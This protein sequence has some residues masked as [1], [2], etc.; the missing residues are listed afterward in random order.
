MDLVLS[1]T[2]LSLTSQLAQ[3]TGAGEFRTEEILQTNTLW[4]YTI[5]SLNRD[6]FYYQGSLIDESPPEF[7]RLPYS[8]SE[9]FVRQLATND[10]NQ[11]LFEIEFDVLEPQGLSSVS[12]QIGSFPRG[13]DIIDA[14]E[15]RGGRIVVPHVLIPATPIHVTVTAVNHNG[16]ETL[17][18]CSM[19]SYYDRSPPLAR[20][21]PIRSVSSHPNKISVLFSL[22]DEFGLDTPLQVAIGTVPGD[23]GNDIMDWTNFNLSSISTQIEDSTSPL[24]EFSFN[25]VRSY[26]LLC[27]A[28]KNYVGMP[29]I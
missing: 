1:P 25:R 26:T 19:S 23:Y 29:H 9:C 13:S 14:S 21:T 22:F 20:I 6:E 24:N 15:I 18:T 5:P 8:H 11:L 16:Y 3:T 2:S 17:A 28:Y 27:D 4:Y 12:Y 10:Y 7:I